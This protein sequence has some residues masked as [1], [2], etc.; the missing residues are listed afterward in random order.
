M[1]AEDHKLYLSI[2]ESH[3]CFIGHF[4]GDPLVPG[5]LMIQWL[6]DLIQ[7]AFPTWAL[8]SLKVMKFTAPVR[9]GDQCEVLLRLQDHKL[10]VECFIHNQLALQGQF[11]IHTQYP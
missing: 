5:A 3:A 1:N 11:L 7:E 2:P 10:T 4:P 9:P 8:S 6:V